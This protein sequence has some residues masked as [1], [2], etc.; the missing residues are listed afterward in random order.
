MSSRSRLIALMV[1]LTIFLT[2]C[3]QTSVDSTGLWNWLVI[4]FA[5]G[6]VFLGSSFGNNLGVGIIMMTLIIRLVMVPLYA[7]QIKSQEEMKTLQPKI[8]KINDKYKDKKD[9]ESQ[10][11]KQQEQQ[12]LY[13]DA[14]INPL[15][16]CLPLLLQMPLLFA[17]YDSLS[18]LMPSQAMIDSGNKVIYGLKEL[19]APNMSTDLFGIDLNN[20]VVIFA[21]FAGV[22][23]Y[24]TTYLSQLGTD[25]TDNPGAGAIKMLMYVMPVMIFVIGL[26]LP[27]ALS[28]YWCVGNL[29]SIGQTV[30]YRR[31][32][33][34]TARQK[35]KFSKK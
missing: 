1:P 31:S 15:A 25:N 12:A 17:F 26:S 20:P 7:K 2:G 30:Y 34:Q 21:L 33:I 5:K 3:Q 18:Y 23:T 10:M 16:G 8:K 11:K 14:G 27:G 19:G 35:S 24:L 4:I 28:I 6:I 32:H 22:T 13:K 9:R 29:V